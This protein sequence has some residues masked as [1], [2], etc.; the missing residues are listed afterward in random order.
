MIFNWS[1]L[2]S[3]KKPSDEEVVYVD[4]KAQHY[5]ETGQEKFTLSPATKEHNDIKSL[6]EALVKIKDLEQ[7][8]KDIE[9]RI[10]KKYPEVKFL[11]FKDRKRI[12]VSQQWS[13]S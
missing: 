10:P 4:D 9:Y 8:L 5:S 13:Y 12:L 11:T 6:D 7:R 1:L 3:S 2:V